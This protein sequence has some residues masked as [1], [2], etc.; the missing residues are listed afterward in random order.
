MLLL[1][2]ITTDNTKKKKKTNVIFKFCVNTKRIS[3]ERSKQLRCKRHRRALIQAKRKEIKFFLKKAIL[4]SKQVRKQWTTVSQSRGHEA[5]CTISDKIQEGGN[6]NSLRKT[7]E[8][9]IFGLFHFKRQ[10][11]RSGKKS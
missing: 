11:R 1:R 10:I 9:A 6:S 5:L 3:C 7:K 4:F 8:R 2:S